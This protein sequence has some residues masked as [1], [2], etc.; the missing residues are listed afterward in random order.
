MAFDFSYLW[1]YTRHAIDLGTNRKLIGW[2]KSQEES[3]D[4]RPWIIRDKARA[5]GSGAR[6][7]KAPAC[8]EHCSVGLERSLNQAVSR[9]PSKLGGLLGL[10]RHIIKQTRTAAPH[11]T[12]SRSRCDH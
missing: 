8:F 12:I 10:R 11:S 6:L 9:R 4:P 3:R 7:K 2:R 1:E 5:V